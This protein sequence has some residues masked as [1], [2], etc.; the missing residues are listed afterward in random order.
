MGLFDVFK[1]LIDDKPVEN[2]Q[3]SL[4][5]ERV[6]GATYDTTPVN[7]GSG[8]FQLW[9]VEM[10]ITSSQF[11]NFLADWYPVLHSVV[12]FDY[13][14]KQGVEVVRVTS[15]D[16][17]KT[18]TGAS[19][20]MGKVVALNFPLTERVPYNSG[21]V[22]VSVGLL[23]LKDKDKIAAAIRL[24]GDMSSLLAVPQLST[25][26]SIAA[27]LANNIESI[28]GISGPQFRLGYHN[29]FNDGPMGSN[30]LRTQY[31]AI[32]APGTGSVIS[33]DGAGHWIANDHLFY[34]E[35]VNKP[36]PRHEV[37]VDYILLRLETYP[38][39]DWRS[40]PEINSSYQ[41]ALVAGFN[42]DV[43]TAAAQLNAAQLRA[44]DL[45]DIAF[46]DWQRIVQDIVRTY[47]EEVSQ[48]VTPDQLLQ[49]ISDT[50]VAA[51]QDDTR[52]VRGVEAPPVF[53]AGQTRGSGQTRG[54][55]DNS[56]ETLLLANIPDELK[57]SLVSPEDI[58]TWKNG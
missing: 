11:M 38:T 29:T 17:L 36:D 21:A 45:P 18:S 12:R 35:D 37:P 33:A 14:N 32:I 13:G 31:I 7:A 23:A 44:H 25:A 50:S 10:Q 16:S 58:L 4:P 19:F 57:V 20:S 26:I 47:K 24:A 39:R 9:A 22:E 27:P 56:Y 46:K 15:L 54:G 43:K 51:V 42:G 30:P 5:P 1:G 28:L 3:F 2:V 55:E 40:L 53:E 34:S 6:L 41:A 49:K 52:V 8:Y 48:M